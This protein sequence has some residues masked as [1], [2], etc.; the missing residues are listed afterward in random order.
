MITDSQALLATDQIIFGIIVIGLIGLAS[1]V[2]FKWRQPAPLPVG[3]TRDERPRSASASARAARQPGRVRA[4]HSSRDGPHRAHL[5]SRSTSRRSRRWRTSRPSTSTACSAPG[6]A[7][8]SATICAGAA[9]RR[10]RLRLLTQPGSSVLEVA[11]AVGFGSGEAF[12]RAFKAPLRRH[13][14]RVARGAQVR[15]GRGQFRSGRAQPRSGAR[16][17]DFDHGF[18]ATPMIEDTT[19]NADVSLID[20]PPT[21]I[22]YFRHTGPYGPPVGA[23]LDGAHGAVDGR[24]RLVR[25][26]ALRHRARRLRPSPS[27]PS[28]ATTPAW[29]PKPDGSAFG[30]AAAHRAARRALRLHAV[31]RH[32]RRHRRRLA[33]TARR[34]AAARA[35]CSSTPG[36]CSSTTR[37]T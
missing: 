11:L 27:L 19:M 25:P 3:A 18:P 12:A 26:R 34:L 33:A 13:A 22:A 5:D 10:A 37:S 16:Q 9:S 17:P 21:P 31:R 2:L 23:L 4:A 28:A 35:A 6:R 15:S 30:P 24:E 14:E 20:M 32:G 7:R 36:R 8:R 1:D 29:R